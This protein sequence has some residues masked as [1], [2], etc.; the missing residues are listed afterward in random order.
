MKVL[1]ITPKFYP[2]LCGNTIT[3]DRI[4]R[5]LQKKGTSV[6]IITPQHYSQQ[7]L[8]LFRPDIV[9][10]FHATKSYL[11]T[12]TV[13]FVVTFT[14]TDINIDLYDKKK[15]PILRRA[16]GG[17]SYITM[18]Q[19]YD[20]KKIERILGIP[21]PQYTIIPQ[22]ALLENSRCNFRKQFGLKKDDFVFL[23]VAGIRAVKDPLYAIHELQR[24]YAIY[25]HLKLVI[26]GEIYDK[27]LYTQI[28]ALNVPWVKI[29]LLKHECMAEAYR[30]SDIIL[31]TS[32]SEGLSTAVV[33]A[34]SL[35]KLVLGSDI[36]GNS[37]IPKNYRFKKV[38]NG[39]FSCAR[40]YIEHHPSP[41]Y[42]LK[43]LSMDEEAKEYVEVYARVLAHH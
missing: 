27:K 32:D 38:K 6:Q 3:V 34:L 36:P 37:I 40:K 35:N 25:P 14:G 28:R 10:F 16:I 20:L 18:F 29:G 21:M 31:N 17:A 33:E 2:D 30:A 43:I 11:D 23:L 5:G 8:L 7:A 19:K 13:P 41:H 42:H 24:L 1:L 4:A 26:L 15:Q 12:F 9:H 22:A 39:L